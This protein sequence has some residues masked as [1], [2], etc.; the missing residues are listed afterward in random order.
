MNNPLRSEILDLATLTKMTDL[1]V[2]ELNS[3]DDELFSYY[4]FLR[5]HKLT[6]LKMSESDISN[7]MSNGFLHSA[8]LMHS[9]K[10]LTSTDLEQMLPNLSP[11]DTA[12][13]RVLHLPNCVTTQVNQ[14]QY[15]SDVNWFSI[16][17][18]IYSINLPNYFWWTVDSFVKEITDGDDFVI[19]VYLVG[20]NVPVLQLSFGKYDF[21]EPRQV[22]EFDLSNSIDPVF[23]CAD[24]LVNTGLLRGNYSY[25]DKISFVYQLAKLYDIDATWRY[26]FV[27][28]VGKRTVLAYEPGDT[29]LDSLWKCLKEDYAWINK[30]EEHLRNSVVSICGEK[31]DLISYARNPKA[32]LEHLHGGL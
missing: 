17:Y 32:F 29:Y 31:L 14:F 26:A 18:G 25:K 4:W 7:I 28:P 3:F 30:P 21:M 1:S 16:Q 20:G 23:E 6:S 11:F 10:H 24:D 9:I 5:E 15:D 12:L 22:I 27:S 8:A 13:Q 19:Q 2:E